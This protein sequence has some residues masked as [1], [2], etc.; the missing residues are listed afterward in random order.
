[1]ANEDGGTVEAR[2]MGNSNFHLIVEK[3]WRIEV[4]EEETRI[5]AQ[6]VGDGWNITPDVQKLNALNGERSRIVFSVEVG[7]FDPRKML[8]II[9]PHEE[10]KQ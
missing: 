9:S 8:D 6:K 1:M 4:H 7:S 5:V 3:R 2:Q 10:P